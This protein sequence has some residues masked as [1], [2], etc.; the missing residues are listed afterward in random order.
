M[1]EN[2]LVPALQNANNNCRVAE[3]VVPS[4]FGVIH[5]LFKNM[6]HQENPMVEKERG[7]IERNKRQILSAI[8]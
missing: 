8:F 1:V 3:S 4:F 6:K 2:C 5:F 7:E